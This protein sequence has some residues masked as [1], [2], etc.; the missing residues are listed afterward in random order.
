MLRKIINVYRSAAQVVVVELTNSNT[1]LTT[2]GLVETLR[3]GV[4]IILENVLKLALMFVED[5]RWPYGRGL[6]TILM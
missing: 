6:E 4:L 3:S 2:T 5:S 1:G